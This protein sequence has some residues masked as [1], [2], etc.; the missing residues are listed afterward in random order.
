MIIVT[1][2]WWYISILLFCIPIIY[3]TF[4][5]PGGDYDFQTDTLL[6]FAICWPSCIFFTLAKLL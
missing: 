6:V 2:H 1:L 5:K 3:A 4:R